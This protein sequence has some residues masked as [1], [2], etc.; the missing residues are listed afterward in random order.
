[1][2]DECAELQIEYDDLLLKPNKSTLD[3]QRIL[4][5]EAALARLYGP[6][7]GDDL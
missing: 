1:M 2:T 6:W 3:C 4:E 7:D 5:I